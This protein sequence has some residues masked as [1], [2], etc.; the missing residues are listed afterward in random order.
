MN[1]ARSI[2]IAT[3]AILF[4]TGCATM[5]V[6]T[7]G[8]I[9]LES[10]LESVG[11]GLVR[12]K[13]AQLQQN[14]GVE[15]QTGLL[16]SEAEVSFNIAASGKQD[17]RLY[18]EM[19]PIPITPTPITGKAGAELGSSL[20]ASRGNQITIKFRNIAFSKKTT[21]PE[22]VVIIEGPTDPELLT[23]T[24]SA[25][26]ASGIKVLQVTPPLTGPIPKAPGP[27]PAPVN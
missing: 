14:L 7:P 25:L 26:K 21:T 3:S 16:P 24:I 1:C 17:G 23:K 13:Q 5:V 18:V 8:T 22:G 2:G 19:S 6:P 10:A 15:F 9:T 4:S 20:T 27:E 11:R 12:M